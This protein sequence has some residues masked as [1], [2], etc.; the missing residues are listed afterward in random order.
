MK[1]LLLYICRNFGNF[2]FWIFIF[3]LMIDPTNSLL[4]KKDIVF[5]IVVAY[6]AM[7]YK[8]DFSK[9]PYIAIFLASVV[10]PYLVATMSSAPMD[11][12]EMLAVFKSV[13]PLLLLF[14]VREYDLVKLSYGPVVLCCIIMSVVYI[15]MLVEPMV[16]SLVWTVMT[17]N[18]DP[19]MMSR[20]TILGFEI[21]GFYLKSFVSFLFAVSYYLLVLMKGKKANLLTVV[22]FLFILF[23]FLIS[24][25]RS[26]MLVPFF[27]FVVIA[28]RVYKNSKYMKYVMMPLVYF[29]AIAFVVVL[30]LAATEEKEASNVVKFGHL[31]SYWQLFDEHPI[32]FLFGQGPGTAFY[33][34]G[35]N[36]VVYK[37]EWSYL[38]LLR[39]FGIFSLGIVFVFF[40]PLVTFWKQ[41]NLDDFTYCMFWSYLSYLAIA[42][43]N[44][45]IMSSTG[46]ITLLMAYSYEEK[47]KR[48]VR[49]REKERLLD[50]EADKHAA[51]V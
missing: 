20:R 4:H 29:L 50:V 3:V 8:P 32:Y 30:V 43:T 10:I 47:V 7:V 38:E 6:N 23:A 51:E 21:F 44:P 2:L 25:T 40:K 45:L 11:E 12:T 33:S 49:Q 22:S 41:R 28:F 18:N 31:T 35:F 19:V 42:G 17:T 37:T 16:E 48:L 15:A 24:G 14:W 27:L 9:I 26:T 1:S 13:A 46:M 34:E 5:C 39:C 36:Q